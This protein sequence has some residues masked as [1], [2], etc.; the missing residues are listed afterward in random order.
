MEYD[1]H[2]FLKMKKSDA[3]VEDVLW[4]SECSSR[5]FV[6]KMLK[7]KPYLESELRD[8]G[9]DA[10]IFFDSKSHHHDTDISCHS[11]RCALR[12]LMRENL[13]EVRY[14]D[15]SRRVYGLTENTK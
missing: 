7:E 15:K 13:I 4:T 6:L 12:T 11:G 2:G 10:G 3:K 9:E 14:D 1:Y 5:E 8:I